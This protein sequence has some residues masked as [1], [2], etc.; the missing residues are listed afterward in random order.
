M[1]RFEVFKISLGKALSYYYL[2][3]YICHQLFFP[4]CS[5]YLYMYICRQLLFP[6]SSRAY[7]HAQNALNMLERLARAARM[8]HIEHGRNATGVYQL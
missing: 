5:Y 6:I 7:Q 2:Y 4:I 1:F 8:Q 3:M